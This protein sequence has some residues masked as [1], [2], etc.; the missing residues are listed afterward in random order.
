[1]QGNPDASPLDN[2]AK[3]AHE[4]IDECPG[5]A[6]KASEILVWAGEIRE[7]RRARL[8]DGLR[9]LVRFAE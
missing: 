7:R 1:M 6:A 4:I 3:L 9:A 2:I 5:C 8:I